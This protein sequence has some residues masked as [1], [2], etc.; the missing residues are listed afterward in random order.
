[1]GG[2][3]C[4]PLHIWNT[5]AF[6]S[7]HRQQKISGNR[8]DDARLL[9]NFIIRKIDFP[10]CFALWVKVWI[11]AEE[12]HKEN[13]FIISRTDISTVCAYYKPNAR[14]YG[15]ILDTEILLVREYR[16]PCCSADGFV[17]ELPGGS[18]FKEDSDVLSLAAHE[19]EEE[20]GIAVSPKRIQRVN[21]RQMVA[22]FST[23][24]AALFALELTKE[25]VEHAKMMGDMP[26]GIVEDSERTYVEVKTVREIIEKNLVDWAM[27][28]MIMEAIK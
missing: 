25:E 7:W 22:T 12:R 20:T 23:H 8:L 21:T 18:S 2:E 16:S 26:H 4:V 24:K 14:F 9:W 10:F 5:K 15:G 27:L 1:M 13:E 17:H 28:G 3:R 6:Q 11:A 19:L